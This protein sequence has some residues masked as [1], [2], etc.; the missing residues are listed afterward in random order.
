M[1]LNHAIIVAYIND[2]KLFSKL[3]DIIGEMV[4]LHEFVLLQ[5]E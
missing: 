4:D 1:F 2:L 3:D 5:V